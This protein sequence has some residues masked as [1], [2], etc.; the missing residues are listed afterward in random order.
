MIYYYQFR[1]RYNE[2][3]K[4]KANNLKQPYNSLEKLILFIDNSINFTKKDGQQTLLLTNFSKYYATGDEGY[5][6]D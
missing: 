5:I 1:E 2:F 4:S 6:Q 3:Q